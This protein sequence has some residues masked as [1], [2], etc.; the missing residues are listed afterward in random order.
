MKNVPKRDSAKPG[1]GPRSKEPQAPKGPQ[2]RARRDGMAGAKQPRQSHGRGPRSGNDRDGR[3]RGRKGEDNVRV[4]LKEVNKS[5]K[6]A[7]YNPFADF[8]KED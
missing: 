7:S 4:D 5:S 6:D 2:H 8:F 3:G 1:R